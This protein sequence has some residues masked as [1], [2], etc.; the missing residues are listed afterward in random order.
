MLPFD[1]SIV[2]IEDIIPV[3]KN[4][5][6]RT[7]MIKRELLSTNHL[8]NP[9]LVTPTKND[10]F[11]L[12]QGINSYH[13]VKSIGLKDVVVQIINPQPE[14]AEFMAWSHLV[15]NLKSEYF[16][17]IADDLQM[18][19]EVYENVPDVSEYRD[20]KQ[21]TC[22]FLNGVSYRI[23][24]GKKDLIGQTKIINRFI[25]AYQ[26]NCSH[27]RLYPDN[28]F[29]RAVELFEE[30]SLLIILPRYTRDEVLA[31]VDENLLLPPDYLNINLDNRVVGLDYPV[32]VLSS[33]VDIEE[34]RSFLNDLIRMRLLSNRSMVFGGK[35]F[36]MG[37]TST[38]RMPT[39]AKFKSDQ[40]QWDSRSE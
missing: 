7:D 3:E 29:L 19:Y 14:A 31:L 2:P 1:L 9:L 13:A 17:Q 8:V 35:V 22:I 34:K 37:K 4:H 27:L 12:L 32:S 6:A 5:P 28:L 36:Y 33:N 25:E 40:I 26:A 10:G 23:E 18:R 24:S 39:P 16:L 38:D 21:I 20:S 30:D 15:R 11:I